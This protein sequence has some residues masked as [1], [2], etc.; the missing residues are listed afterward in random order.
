MGEHK[1]KSEQNQRFLFNGV[2]LLAK[3]WMG[4]HANNFIATPEIQSG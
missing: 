2:H 4:G 3:L 1:W